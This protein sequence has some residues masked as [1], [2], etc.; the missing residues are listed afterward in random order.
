LPLGAPKRQTLDRNL[1]EDGS[2]LAHHADAVIAGAHVF[3]WRGE[4][5]ASRAR[6]VPEAAMEAAL[7]IGHRI[8]EW[9][10]SDGEEPQI[11]VSFGAAVWP[12]DGA[13]P[14]LLLRA[15][16]RQLYLMKRGAPP[17]STKQPLPNR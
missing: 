17:P 2:G 6:I 3:R 12:E 15:A 4:S 8:C 14:D 9:L 5:N 7:G 11:S 16:D 13:L 10:L 1:F